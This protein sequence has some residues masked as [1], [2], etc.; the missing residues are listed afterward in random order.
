MEDAMDSRYSP[1][2]PQRHKRGYDEWLIDQSIAETF[3]ASDATTATRPGSI[4]WKRNAQRPQ[5]RA[6]IWADRIESFIRTESTV[7]LVA[8]ALVAAAWLASRSPGS[9]SSE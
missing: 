5:R 9:D 6:Q 3:P 2:A 1:R 4:A 8:A 7:A